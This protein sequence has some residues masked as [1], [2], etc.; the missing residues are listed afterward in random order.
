M[1]VVKRDVG[2]LPPLF[3]LGGDNGFAAILEPCLGAGENV[4]I[5]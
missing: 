5:F 1:G 4:A 3:R 2:L